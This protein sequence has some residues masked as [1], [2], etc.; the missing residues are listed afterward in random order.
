MPVP[1]HGEDLARSSAWP[2]ARSPRVRGVRDAARGAPGSSAGVAGQGTN[3]R[4]SPA[5]TTDTA[6]SGSGASTR[7]S[8]PHGFG[9]STGGF[10]AVVACGSSA[11]LGPRSRSSSSPRLLVSSVPCRL[12]SSYLVS[13]LLVPCLVV[14]SLP[15]VLVSNCAARASSLVVSAAGAAPGTNRAA[16]RTASVYH[17]LHAAKAAGSPGFSISS[18]ARPAAAT[19]SPTVAAIV[20]SAADI[21]QALAPTATPTF[22]ISSGLVLSGVSKFVW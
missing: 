7:S 10:E 5:R 15:G 9:T 2:P 17:F 4:E 22:R 18:R 12:V 11:T 19:M 3:W 21:S 6:V 13:R 8:S 14:S 16:L 20:S 1:L